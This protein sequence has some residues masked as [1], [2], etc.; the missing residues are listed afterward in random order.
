MSKHGGGG[1]YGAVLEFKREYFK[2]YIYISN[3]ER[4]KFG[5]VRDF[6]GEERKKKNEKYI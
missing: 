3:D 5:D 4:K 2:K 6:Q 1:R